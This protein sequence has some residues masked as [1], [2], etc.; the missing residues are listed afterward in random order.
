[1][2][3]FNIYNEEFVIDNDFEKYNEYRKAIFEAVR[4]SIQEFDKT[5]KEHITDLDILINKTPEF[6]KAIIMN[7][8]SAYAIRA[9][10]QEGIANISAEMFLEKYYYKY[11]NFDEYF[12]P[13]LEKYVEITEASESL[14]QYREM[15]KASRSRWQGGGFGVKGAIKGAMTAGALNMGADVL[16]SFGDSSKANRDARKINSLKEELYNSTSTGWSIHAN[17]I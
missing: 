16:R 10:V 13:L 11:L 4:I 2:K 8:I 15:Q 14:R 3:V 17:H 6:A 7:V 5:Y 12:D 1:M 9:L